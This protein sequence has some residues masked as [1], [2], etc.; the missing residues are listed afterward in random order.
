MKGNNNIWLFSFADLAFLL[1]IAFTQTST[2]GK[3]PVSIGEMEIPK[4]VDGP[5]ISALTQPEVSYQVRVLRPVE[6]KS[7]PYQLVV[8]KGSEEL[9]MSERLSAALLRDRLSELRMR[10]IQ[11]PIMVPDELSL[12]KDMLLA[13]SVIGKVWDNANR[14]T[15][16]RISDAGTVTN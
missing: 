7:D 16:E 10:G 15:V 4:V 1:L 11:R 12:S 2:I 6:E 13:M 14:V 5:Q 8:M 9:S 3:T